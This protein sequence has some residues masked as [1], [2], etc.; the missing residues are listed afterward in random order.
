MKFFIKKLGCPKN[1]VDGDYIAARLIDA[2]HKPV[3]IDAEA[4]IVIVNTCGFIL[5]AK[6]ESIEEILQYEEMKK[7][8]KI[9]RL[10]VTG[11]LSQ[12]YGPDSLKE[13]EGVDAI[14]GLGDHDNIVRAIDT[15]DNYKSAFEYGK[16][17]DIKYISGVKRYF[18]PSYPYEYLKISDGC[19]RY[20]AYCAIPDIRGRYRSRPLAEL[21]SEAEQAADKGKKELILV[22]QEGTGYGR[23]LKDGTDIIK[24]LSGLEKI[25][26]ISWI[27]LMY[28][29]PESINDNLI[30]YMAASS[31]VLNYFDIPLQHINNR[32]L[33]LMNRRVTRADIESV[34]E[35]IRNHAPEATIRTSFIAGF[36]GETEEEFK[37]LEDFVIATGFERLGVFGYSPEEGTAAAAMENQNSVEI[38][39][40]RQDRLMAVQQEIAFKKNIDLI[41]TIQQVIIDRVDTGSPSVGR[42]RGDCPDIDQMVYIDDGDLRVCDIIDVRVTMAEGY[43]LIAK[44]EKV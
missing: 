17:A 32:L 5:P 14:F 23:E 20:C 15:G 19:N 1:D 25:E 34:I 29:H 41:G 24:L 11:C 6:E 30:K 13:I 27:R 31:K 35:N 40:E 28:L 8:G 33:N 2:G 39:G 44:T 9:K 3:D 12:R 26:G 42:T 22:S 7:T 10:Y 21:L 4:D 16:S 36:P 38:V 18:D 37:E 43:D